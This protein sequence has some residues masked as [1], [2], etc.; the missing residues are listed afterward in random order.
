MSE[1]ENK[2]VVTLS[3]GDAD[4]GRSLAVPVMA[5][6]WWR[7]RDW[8]VRGGV[9]PLDTADRGSQ[10]MAQFKA[11]HLLA[12]LQAAKNEASA[13]ASTAVDV[14]AAKPVAVEHKPLSSTAEYGLAEIT[15]CFLRGEHVGKGVKSAL[16]MPLMPAITKADRLAKQSG[17]FA[18]LLKATPVLSAGTLTMTKPIEAVSVK[19]APSSTRK[20]HLTNR[21]IWDWS[22]LIPEPEQLTPAPPSPEVV[23]E[24]TMPAALLA[25]LPTVLQKVLP[26]VLGK[27]LPEAFLRLPAE[28]RHQ[29][30]RKMSVMGLAG[31][32]METEEINR[33][34]TLSQ[35]EE[36]SQFWPDLWLKSSHAT[37]QQ[38]SKTAALKAAR[39]A[40]LSVADRLKQ[41]A[42]L[43]KTPMITSVESTS[44]PQ[45]ALLSEKIES[46]CVVSAP[47]DSVEPVQVVHAACESVEP[48][49]VVQVALPEGVEFAPVVQSVERPIVKPTEEVQ[50]VVVSIAKPVVDPVAKLVVEPVVEPVVKLV[51]ESVTKPMVEPVLVVKCAPAVEEQIIEPVLIASL[52]SDQLG[53]SRM[54]SKVISAPEPTQA[55]VLSSPEG[56]SVPVESL[57]T[58]VVHILADAAGVISVKRQSG[59]SRP[60]PVLPSDFYDQMGGTV[61]YGG[62]SVVAGVA[63]VIAGSVGLVVG[64][65]GCVI[66]AVGAMG[67]GVLGYSKA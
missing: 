19:P 30:I 63:G 15:G 46:V 31:F 40:V 37:R 38:A 23:E 9:N 47:V 53:D 60:Q 22:E 61:Y 43:P 20:T 13:S 21:I 48:V 16:P 29:L 6:D 58:G 52:Q 17:A 41:D 14:V 44:E 33:H 39:A 35:Q 59:P 36:M 5:A 28:T 1:I 50:N 67:R 56:S 62:Q 34:L 4:H 42:V 11:R 54:A 25:A 7:T 10:S 8:V 65:A 49:E 3:E 55:P 51:V 66:G 12:A 18:H 45:P 27:A 24:P 26:E 32:S 64:T 2:A 57:T